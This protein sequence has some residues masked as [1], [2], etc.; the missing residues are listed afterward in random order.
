MRKK[1]PDLDAQSPS[2]PCPVRYRRIFVISILAF[3]AYWFLFVMGGTFDPVKRA[4][5]K[6]T[7]R[8]CGASLTKV[9]VAKQNTV[10]VT[11]K[12]KRK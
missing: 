10:A 6:K 5:L 4:A 7:V 9:K 8:P 2:A 3:V 11:A 1:S 12:T